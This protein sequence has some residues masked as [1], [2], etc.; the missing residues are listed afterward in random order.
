MVDDGAQRCMMRVMG[1]AVA[2][3]SSLVSMED[4][5]GEDEDEDEWVDREFAYARMPRS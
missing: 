1:S 5:V 2:C 3:C 4:M